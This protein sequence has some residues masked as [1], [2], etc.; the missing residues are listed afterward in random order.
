MSVG[1]DSRITPRDAPAVPRSWLH[2][3]TLESLT[4]LNDQCLEL[5]AEQAGIGSGAGPPL[6]HELRDLWTMLD[7]AAR[8]RAAGCPYLIVD[9]GFADPRNWAAGDTIHESHRG[10]PPAAPFFSGPRA[11]NL[12]R[13][14]LTYGWHLARSRPAAAR[15]LLGMSALCA[16]RIAGCTL[17][18]IAFLAEQHPEWLQPRWSTRVCVWR[19]LLRAAICGDEAALERARMRGLQLLAAETRAPGP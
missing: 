15:V 16:E 8:Q 14:A 9:A 6:L 10:A 19:E 18:Q 2:G 5:L 1:R 7:A 3:E 12:L 13:L 11:G 17:R 4:E